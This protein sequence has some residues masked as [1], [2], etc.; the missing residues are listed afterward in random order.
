M[1]LRTF[2]SRVLPFFAL[3]RNRNYAVVFFVVTCNHNLIMKH[4]LFYEV[5]RTYLLAWPYKMAANYI[6]RHQFAKPV[7]VS[8]DYSG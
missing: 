2:A 5:Y 6:G 4:K 3:Y 1:M 7:V 8:R